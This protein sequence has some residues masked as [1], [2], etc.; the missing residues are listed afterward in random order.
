MWP[1]ATSPAVRKTQQEKVQEK[2]KFM[3]DAKVLSNQKTT[4]AG[5]LS[6]KGRTSVV[7]PR[8]RTRIT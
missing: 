7:P 3:P 4:L 5:G 6:G 1:R 8:G 2:R